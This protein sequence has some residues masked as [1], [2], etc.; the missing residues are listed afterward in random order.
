[1]EFTSDFFVGF[2]FAIGC[3]CWAILIYFHFADA[4]DGY[5]PPAVFAMVFALIIKVVSY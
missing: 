5:I 1:M 3:V 4:Y 2:L